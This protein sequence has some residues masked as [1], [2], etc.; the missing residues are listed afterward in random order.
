[1]AKSILGNEGKPDENKS[2]AFCVFRLRRVCGAGGLYVR[3]AEHGLAVHSRRASR[4]DAGV[5]HPCHDRLAGRH[6]PRPPRD[7][8]R[9]PSPG[10]RRAHVH[11]RK[12]RFQRP[13]LDV[14]PRAPRRRHRVRLLV[15]PRAV[16]RLFGGYG[17]R[18][19]PLCVHERLRTTLPPRRRYARAV[20]EGQT[21]LHVRRRNGLSDALAQR[22][23][24][25]TSSKAGT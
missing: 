21:P 14:C 8:V 17:H 4:R 6:G 22:T 10:R 24:R 11:L 20:R 7:A 5:R 12:T 19:V 1:M 16:R 15:R 3:G 18:V 25:G 13:G 23:L 2:S 9:V